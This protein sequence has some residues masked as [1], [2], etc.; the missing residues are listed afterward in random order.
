MQTNWHT[1][2]WKKL[3][4]AAA[5]AFG[6]F[7][8]IDSV[9]MQWLPNF[10]VGLTLVLPGAWFTI[11][12]LRS[13]RAA[14]VGAPQ[15]KRHWGL[16]TLSSF[17]LFAVAVA[18]VPDDVGTEYTADETS[19]SPSATATSSTEATTIT[20]EPT[21]SEESETPEPTAETAVE[22]P[23]DN[24]VR[25]GFADLGD[26]DAPDPAYVAPEPAYEPPAPAYEAPA[27][28]AVGGFANCSEARAAGYSNILAGSPQYASKLDRDGDGV[29]CES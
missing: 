21:T 8:I 11:H 18:L 13:R 20:T 24:V 6:T 28:A 12:E 5:L 15:L 29:A 22:E 4:A 27:P 2:L 7:T 10:F 1:P 19:T 9:H 17:A 14:A 3:L 26:A 23:T 25:A 16:V